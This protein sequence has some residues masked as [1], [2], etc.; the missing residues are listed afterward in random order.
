[1]S[2]DDYDLIFPFWKLVLE[3]DMVESWLMLRAARK[4][5]VE[6]YTQKHIE[7]EKGGP[8]SRRSQG[9]LLQARSAELLA[10]TRLQR[11]WSG[12]LV[13]LATG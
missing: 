4:S 6:K 9:L 2:K 10:T 8:R 11:R 1:M 13:N 12:G 5:V 3:H 7:S